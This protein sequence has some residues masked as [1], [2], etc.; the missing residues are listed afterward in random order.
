MTEKYKVALDKLKNTC[1]I[2]DLEFET[3]A[4]LYPLQGI[5]GQR[6]ASESL[7]FGL[8]MKKKG[9]NVFVSGQSGTGRN[10]YVLS[11][12]EKKAETKETPNDWAYVYNYKHPDSP[13]ALKLASGMGKVFKKDIEGFI[14][15]LKKEIPEKFLGK[16]YENKKNDLVQQYQAYSQGI[17]DELNKVA[18]NHGFQFKQSERGQIGRASC[19]ERV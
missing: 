4:D 6:R 7:D 12:T 5:I 17:L 19:R 2:G 14:Q 10:S 16:E 13:I 15:T 1:N 11:I 18:Q 9:Y 3:T 8:D